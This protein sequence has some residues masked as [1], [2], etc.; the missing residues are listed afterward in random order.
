MLRSMML[1]LL[2]F[3]VFIC[4]CNE[5]ICQ[6]QDD[7]TTSLKKRRLIN[8]LMKSIS[9]NDTSVNPVKTV[10]PFLV[11]KGKIIRSII[12]VP[13]GFDRNLYDT[14]LLRKNFPTDVANAF[15]RNTTVE[16]IRK[17]LFFHQY[18]K[19]LPLLLADNERFL[20]EQDF[21]QDAIILVGK[22]DNAKDSIDVVVFTKDVFSIGGKVN[23]SNTQKARVEIREENLFGTGNRFSVGM[24]YDKTRSPKFGYGAEYTK[25]NIDGRFINWTTG[26]K[27]FNKEILT[28]RM[29]ENVFYTKIEK[30]LVSRYSQWTGA[31]ELSYNDTHNNYLPDSPALYKSNY[32]Y[33]YTGFDLWGGYNFGGKDKKNTDSDKRLRHF[34]GL[35]AFYT[36]FMRVPT[37]YKDSFD[38]KYA[39][40]NAALFSYTLYKQNFYRTNFI[41]GFGRNEDVPE[42]ISASII[43]G[44]TNKQGVRRSYLGIDFAATHFSQ[45]GYFTSY[46]LRYGAFINKKSFQDIDWLFSI[47]HFTR[48]RELGISWRNRNFVSASYTKQLRPNLNEPL[49]IGSEFGLPYYHNGSI[50][51]D[52]RATLKIE[53]VFYNLNKF[54]GF[55]FAPFIFSDFSFLKPIGASFEKTKGYSAIGGG[56]RARNENLV[57]ETI[58]L[59]AYLLPNHLD[60]MKSWR[61]D[62]TTKLRFKYNS[63]FIKKPDFV[64]A[65]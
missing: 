25:R 10:N 38:Y 7:T 11:H 40:I 34:V 30:P 55:R 33:N 36:D 15:H 22:T 4:L 48:L 61:V 44:Y 39:D 47:D 29:E 49:Q 64:V 65:N 37:I 1:R 42:G 32:T 62:L 45:R 5:G 54:V 19:V 53:S 12:I 63:S 14:T 23:I 13:L 58:E 8:K 3:T 24:L 43:S 59:R 6:N 57:F 27:T 35:R 9:K 28:N 26:F 21:L 50:F 56:F 16:V 2:F 31:L 60:N 51:A 20:R 46:T 41:Y 17:N 52:T 18:D